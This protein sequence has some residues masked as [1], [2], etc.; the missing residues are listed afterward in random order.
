MEKKENEWNRWNYFML[1]KCNSRFHLVNFFNSIPSIIK[2]SFFLRHWL[3][4]FEGNFSCFRKLQCDA[5]IMNRATST[6][7]IC[8]LLLLDSLQNIRND[9]QSIVTL[10]PFCAIER[11][12]KLLYHTPHFVLLYISSI[13]CYAKKTA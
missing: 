9:N 13:V 10:P 12:W 2:R 5:T 8:L 3:L 4:Y 1:E 6:N 11:M 7:C